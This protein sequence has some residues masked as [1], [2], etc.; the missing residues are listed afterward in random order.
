[1]GGRP[2]VPADDS[3][4]GMGGRPV[5]PA[6]DSDDELPV[7]VA[8]AGI[9]SVLASTQDENE[10][11][12]DEDLPSMPP[13]PSSVDAPTRSF[14]LLPPLHAGERS[15][16]V[17]STRAAAEEGFA[18]LVAMKAH[19]EEQLAAIGHT[20]LVDQANMQLHLSSPI[21]TSTQEQTQAPSPTPTPTPTPT[22]A[23]APAPA[24]APTRAPAVAE[25]NSMEE[26]TAA[27][28]Q[29]LIALG[30]GTLVG[31]GSSGD[32]TT[33][34]ANAR[35]MLQRAQQQQQQQ[36]HHQDATETIPPEHD[37][38]VAAGVQQ[39]QQ[40]TAAAHHQ[41]VMEHKLRKLG[42]GIVPVLLEDCC[43]CCCCCCYC[44]IAAAAAA[45]CKCYG[46]HTC[47]A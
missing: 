6:D 35:A 17:Q 1:M 43:C 25:T 13:T 9:T 22:P 20:K 46:D 18:E 42:Y 23:P 29:R 5:V 26:Y 27:M 31:A 34:A 30:Y 40:A 38:H 37:I 8:A 12:E 15:D 28:Q 44:A 4:D 36:Q 2:V 33:L 7:V 16:A 10:D 41:A 24:P 39:Q 11:E 47:L 32:A 14:A 45:V 19:L 21:P 3:D